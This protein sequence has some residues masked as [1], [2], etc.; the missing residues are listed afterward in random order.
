VIEV[1]RSHDDGT[2]PGDAVVAGRLVSVNVGRPRDIQWEG[3]TVRTAVWKNPVAGPAMVRQGN[4]DG[5]EQADKNGHGGEHRAVFVYQLD[6]YRYWSDHLGR[7]DFEHGQFGE[8]FTVE[9]LSDG[10]VCIGDRYRIGEA[11]FEVTQPRV[12]CFRVGIRMNQPDMPSLLVAH[13]RPGFYLR[14]LTEGT[15]QSGQAIERVAVGP[16]QVSVVDCDALLYLPHKSAQ[17]LQRVLR[18]PALSAGWRGSFEAMAATPAAPPAAAWDG[19][20]PLRVSRVQPESDTI[21]SFVLRPLDEKAPTPR[22]E[23]GQYLT[24]RLQPEGESGPP[25]VRSYSM[26]SVAGD[27]G[28][29]ISVRRV[30]D[31]V[32]SSYLHQRVHEGDIVAVAAPRGSFVLRDGQRPVVLLSAGVG[33]TPVLAM[34]QALVTRKDQREVWWVHG[35]RDRSEHA[36]G[37]E[38]DELLRAL[39]RSHRLVSYSNPHAQKTDS[40]HVDIVGRISGESLRQ[41]AVPVDADY[42]LC[43]PDAFMKTLSAAIAARGAPPQQIATELFGARSTGLPP[44]M[45]R[46]PAPHQPNSDHGKGPTVSFTRSNLTVRWDPAHGNLLE[47]AEACDVPAGFGCRNGVCHACESEI[48]SG[49]VHYVTPPLEAPDDR[50]VLLCCAAPTSDLALEL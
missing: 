42:Y 36:F 5:D 46:G 41:A 4:I 45:T 34:L 27:D 7:D 25:V 29:R 26:S 11:L 6:S 20:T 50:R 18:V 39:P 1:H 30:R 43:G 22:S 16:E 15:V 17:I 12:T 3:R 9:G 21:T 44:G 48:L 8:N 28:Y 2:P 14:V 49:T 10:E 23:A 47:L 37:S 19:F 13:H 35:A 40:P 24:L 38:V 31:G 33:A 32:G